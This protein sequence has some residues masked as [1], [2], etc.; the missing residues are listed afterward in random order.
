M[1]GSADDVVS[2][3]PIEDG[4]PALLRAD[5]FCQRFVGG[6]DDVLAPVLLTIDN[7]DA[8]VDPDVAPMDFVEWL[9]SW[10][11]LQLDP[12]WDQ[13]RA[14]RT[15]AALAAIN[16]NRGTLSALR[17][18]AAV[19]GDGDIEVE[20]GGGVWTTL[21]PDD[22]LPGARSSEVLVRGDVSD[23]H[24]PLLQSFVPPGRRVV[25]AGT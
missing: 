4:L 16:R 13:R 9:A 24:L 3:M 23:R 20:D 2:S 21:D 7:L 8:Y 19:L 6:L 1:R 15:V 11:G 10:F 25:L 17:D 18:L 12:E 14:R 5:D 22:S